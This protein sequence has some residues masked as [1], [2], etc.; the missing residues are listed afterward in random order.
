MKGKVK[1]YNTRKGYG[2]IEGEDKQDVFLHN[3][4]VPQGVT[5]EEN[6]EL[7]YK[8]EKT[9]RGLKAVDIIKI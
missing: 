8:V 9:D 6:D 5:L 4:D 2:F 3:T 7:E 1:W